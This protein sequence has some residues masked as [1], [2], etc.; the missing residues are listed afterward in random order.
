MG[1]LYYRSKKLPMFGLWT[2]SNKN[3]KHKFNLASH[4]YKACF[5]QF[6]ILSTELITLFLIFQK[7]NKLK[8]GM[9]YG[10]H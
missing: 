1:H 3:G 9:S 5:P 8:S 4:K 2:S 6:Y 10:S 7:L